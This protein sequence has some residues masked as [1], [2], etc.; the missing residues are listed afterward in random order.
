VRTINNGSKNE[1]ARYSLLKKSK[2]IIMRFGGEWELAQYKATPKSMKTATTE[3]P[4][5]LH[6]PKA[7]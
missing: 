6:K 3:A 1:E 2:Q 4:L 7:L 5:C